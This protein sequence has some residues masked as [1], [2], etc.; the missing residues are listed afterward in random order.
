MCVGACFAWDMMVQAFKFNIIT[1]PTDYL[2]E[3][4]KL[5]KGNMQQKEF[6][7]NKIYEAIR[8][9]NVEQEQQREVVNERNRERLFLELAR[10]QQNRIKVSPDVN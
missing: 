3:L 1:S 7:F 5:P 8:K 9:K 10:Q 4:V 2:R 6:E